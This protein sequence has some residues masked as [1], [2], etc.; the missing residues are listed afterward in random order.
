MVFLDGHI[1]AGSRAHREGFRQVAHIRHLNG[2]AGFCIQCEVAV[3]VG[4]DTVRRT[5][6]TYRSTDDGSELIR[7]RT[8]NLLGLLHNRHGHWALASSSKRLR[9]STQ[10]QR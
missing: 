3:H 8:S 4:D 9:R 5:F 2:L 6:H 10:H 7:H 1:V